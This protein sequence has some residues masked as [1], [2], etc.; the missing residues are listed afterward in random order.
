MLTDLGYAVLE[1]ASA[2]EAIQL[3]GSGV[4]PQLLM[5]DHLMTGMNG[6]DLARLVRSELP[7]TQVLLVSGYAESE[8]VAPDLPRMVKPFNISDL[9]AKLASLSSGA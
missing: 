7:G 8:G 3:I 1:A 2:E 4:N 5:T 6:T 9:A